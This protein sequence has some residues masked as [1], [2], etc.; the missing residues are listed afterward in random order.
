MVGFKSEWNLASTLKTGLEKVYTG[1]D[2]S[3][4]GGS[5]VTC[6]SESQF[7]WSLFP[8]FTDEEIKSVVEILRVP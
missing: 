6:M 4:S 2:Y 8:Q 7:S 5:C 3:T 1:S